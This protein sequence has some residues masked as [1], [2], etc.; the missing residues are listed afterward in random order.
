MLYCPKCQANYEDGTQRFC[1]N[2]GARLLPYATSEKSGQLSKGVFSSI[3]SKSSPKKEG[4]ILSQTESVKKKSQSSAFQPPNQSKFFKAGKSK[5]PVEKSEPMVEEV[6]EQK[7]E[8]VQR[9]SFETLPLARIINP[10]LI[11]EKQAESDKVFSAEPEKIKSKKR[12]IIDFSDASQNDVL[13]SFEAE[14]EDLIKADENESSISDVENVDPDITDDVPFKLVEPPPIQDEFELNLEKSESDFSN[15]ESEINLDLGL[16]EDSGANSNFDI[17]FSEPV[18]TVES[19]QQNSGIE[20][21]I[22]EL[23]YLSVPSESIEK[24]EL[25]LDE[26]EDDSIFE[27]TSTGVELDVESRKEINLADSI[28]RI[29]L[30]LAELDEVSFPS[31]SKPSTESAEL[32]GESEI[33]TEKIP[34]VP[35][36]F[37]EQKE[38]KAETG[39]ESDTVEKAKA[40]AAGTS[41]IKATE[42]TAWEKRSIDPPGEEESRWFLYPLIG[43]IILGLGLLGFF[44]L[45]NQNNSVN[46]GQANTPTENL[47]QPNPNVNINAPITSPNEN[48]APVNENTAQFQQD[49]NTELIEVPPP[50]RKVVQPPNTVYFKNEKKSTKGKLAAGFLG[51]S[52]YYPKTWVEKKRSDKFLDISRLTPQGLLSKQLIIERYDSKGTFQSDRPLFKGLVEKSNADLRKIL[53][54]YE[55]LSSEETTFQNGRWQVF[56]VRFQGIGSDKK[57]IIWGRRLW[58]PIQSPGMKSGFIITMIGTSLSDDVKSVN[59]LGEKDDLAEILKTFEPELN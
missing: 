21:E 29:E 23:D 5:E 54:N 58:M 43:I 49:P 10:G 42:D 9:K 59:D 57:L 30:D 3:L 27:P 7:S 37:E 53:S 31:D 6:A 13:E 46:E 28:P 11:P 35:V 52:I 44:Y 47:N 18:E 56:E 19:F 55:V 32:K 12:S 34:P 1:T 2:E 8:I 48:T 4:S 15:S 50:P 39:E 22:D 17:D 25:D 36:T 14:N 20:L 51:F 45:T 24:I 16:D 38:D 26:I 33:E 41:K 40:A